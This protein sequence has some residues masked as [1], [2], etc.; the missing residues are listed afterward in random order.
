MEENYMREPD[1][2]QPMIDHLRNE[3]YAIL[4][5]NRGRHSGPDIVAEKSGRK[6]IIQMKGDSASIKTDWDTGLG[7]LLDILDDEKADYAM[8]VSESYE[9]FVR[10]FPK[11]VKDKLKLTIY[12]VH[13]N[14]R[15]SY[16]S[17]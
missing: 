11:Y 1:M 13:D 16:E 10:K 15:I 7:Q 6:L 4:E 5:V 3:G 2:F 9:R 17:Y 14:G 12:I 8:A